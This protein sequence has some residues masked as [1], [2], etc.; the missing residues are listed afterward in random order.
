MYRRVLAPLDGSE[1]AECTLEHVRQVVKGCGIPEL[2]ILRVAEPIST[3]EAAAYAELTTPPNIIEQLEASDEKEARG[4][5]EEVG[6]RLRREG[7]NV[8]TVFAKGKP[9]DEILSYAEKNAVDLIIISTHGRSGVARW[10]F[11]SVAEKVIRHSKVPVLV[12]TPP[13]CRL[14]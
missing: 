7:I 12:I 6:D 1:L 13:G 9:A 11:G 4:Y 3:R 8:F 5:L 14:A 2:V 10:F